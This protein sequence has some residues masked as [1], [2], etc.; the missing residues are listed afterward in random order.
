MPV[1]IR[2]NVSYTPPSIYNIQLEDDN[3]YLLDPDQLRD[4]LPQ[5]H[6]LLA[7]YHPFLLETTL[8]PPPPSTTQPKCHGIVVEI[9]AKY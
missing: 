1:Y 9:K 5:V 7:L 2:K 4:V 3:D 8:H 6:S